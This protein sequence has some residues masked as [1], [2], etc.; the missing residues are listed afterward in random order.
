MK[1][2][3]EA[4]I[5]FRKD[6]QNEV[7]KLRRI[8]KENGN[9][10]YPMRKRRNTLRRNRIESWRNLEWKREVTEKEE[11]FYLKSEKKI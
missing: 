5:A 3:K 11:N 7:T 4:K 9:Y 10:S 2:K 1:S 8:S 6:Y